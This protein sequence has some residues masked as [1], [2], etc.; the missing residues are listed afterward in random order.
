[1]TSTITIR[2]CDQLLVD[3]LLIF[4]CHWWISR[5]RNK[6]PEVAVS[7][8]YLKTIKKI[9]FINLFYGIE[10]CPTN[11]SVRHLFE[12]NKIFGAMSKDSYSYIYE[13]FGID[14]A[15]QFN[16]KRQ[17]KF[18]NKFCASDNLS[19]RV[20]Y[21]RQ[22][23]TWVLNWLVFS[24]VYYVRLFCLIGYFLLPHVWWNKVVCKNSRKPRYVCR[25]QHD[26]TWLQLDLALCDV[27][28][29]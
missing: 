5:L 1:M 8:A 21:G 27:P 28:S 2:H 23:L 19:C 11:S 20:I 7:T 14:T 24:L 29:S 16:R 17:D 18:I 26:E 10:A 12:F 22:W 6:L 25:R 15:D 4:F 3:I 13:C 9:S